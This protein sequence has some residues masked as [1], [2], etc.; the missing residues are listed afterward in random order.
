MK[1]HE[2]TSAPKDDPSNTLYI[3]INIGDGKKER[4]VVSHH[5]DP[6][7]VALKFAQTHNLDSGS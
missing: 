6:A 1:V 4:I 2:G 5:D 3:D 7:S